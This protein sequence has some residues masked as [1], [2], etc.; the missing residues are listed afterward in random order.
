MRIQVSTAAFLCVAVLSWA[1][2]ALAGVPNAA[3]S[4]V[5]S[6]IQL[7]GSTGG[8]PDAQGQAMVIVN[9]AGGSP[10]ANHTVYID[11]EQCATPVRDIHMSLAQPWAVLGNMGWSCPNSP[12][13][14]PW[15][16]QTP[17][18][19]AITNTSGVATF[20]LLGAAN[21]TP[22]N[23]AGITTPCARLWLGVGAPIPLIVG[24][25][26]LNG[27]G[28]VNAADQ[29]LFLG[30]LFGAYRARADYNGSGSVTAADL[31]RLLAV[32]FAAGSTVSAQFTCF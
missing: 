24:A 23:S 3:T 13:G 9:D 32:Q 4:S 2:P 31:S 16:T 15:P 30:T 5:P 28:G 10:V 27:A 7:V 22:G 26:D 25:Y 19:W 17:A 8:V 21:A 29:S 20:R 12:P 11:F 18:A 1:C 14:P 6:G